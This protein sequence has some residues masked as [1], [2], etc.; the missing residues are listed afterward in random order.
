MKYEEEITLLF[1][2]KFTEVEK[3]LVDNMDQ[4]TEI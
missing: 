2:E 1:V 4:L 3:L